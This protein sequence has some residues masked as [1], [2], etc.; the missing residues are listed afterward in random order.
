MN[1]TAIEMDPEVAKEK[2]AEYRNVLS[3]KHKQAIDDE[4]MSIEQAYKELAKGTPLI[5]PFQAIRGCGWRPDGRPVL[6]MARA[7]QKLCDFRLGRDSRRWD[8][9][10][11]VYHGQFA[12]CE[13]TFQARKERW[14]SQRARNLSI[15]VP[16]VKV[17]P[18]VEPREG[19]AMIP[20]VPAEAYPSSGRLALEKHFIL[21]EVE[22]WDAAP[23]V[24]PMLL[25]PIGGDLYAVIHQWNLTEIERVVIA[26]TRRQ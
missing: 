13:F 7:D 3:K 6:A 25:R 8:P 26:R 24:D 22:D 1:V 21:W 23:P 4:F 18:P 20:L 9:D 10:K 19:T 14:D 5:N 16:N 15:T 12:P 2:L 11:H 17:Q